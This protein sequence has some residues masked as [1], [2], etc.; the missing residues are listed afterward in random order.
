M[1]GVELIASD[2]HR[3]LGYLIALDEQGYHPTERELDEYAEQ[4]DRRPALRATA[5]SSL[6]SSMAMSMQMLSASW[7]LEPGERMSEHFQRLRWALPL[8]G[9][10]HVTPLGRALYRALQ[11]RTPDPETVLDVVIEATDSTAF[12]RVIGRIATS[13]PAL[14]IEPYFRLDVLMP[15]IEYTQ[16]TRV[17]ASERTSQTDRDTLKLAIERLTLTR[18]FEVRVASRVVHDRYVIPDTGAVQFIGASLNGLGQV[19]TAMGTLNDG[20]DDIRRLYES[21]WS[22]S[23]TH[24]RAQTPQA[25]PAP[26]KKVAKARK[27]RAS[28]T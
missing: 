22:H 3:S 25:A 10:L 8:D 28:K 20:S 12:A 13:G 21:I 17:L 5:L 6:A 4:P 27:K 9:R 19:S 26:A 16:V 2:A 15:V 14:L 18:P 11:Q 7:E 24:A 23:P 1:G